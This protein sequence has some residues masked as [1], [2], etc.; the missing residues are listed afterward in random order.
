MR[1][2]AAICSY[3]IRILVKRAANLAL[4]LQWIHT[5]AMSLTKK[6]AL[7]NPFRG[8]V[9]KALTFA[10]ALHTLC[11][12]VTAQLRNSGLEIGNW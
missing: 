2:G 11:R 6:D 4:K 7:L 8:F 9:N 5:C 12:V 1:R 10:G 3:S